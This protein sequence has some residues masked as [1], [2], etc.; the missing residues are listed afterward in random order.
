MKFLPMLLTLAFATPSSVFAEERRLVRAPS[1]LFNCHSDSS[2]RFL[3]LARRGDGDD[4]SAYVYVFEKLGVAQR[5]R[6]IH[7]TALLNRVRSLDSE[8]STDGRFYIT[9]DD[10]GEETNCPLSIVIYDLVRN[11]YYKWSASEF[12]PVDVQKSLSRT[13]DRLHWRDGS[14]AFNRL[15]TRFFPNEPGSNLPFVVV[16]LPTRNVRIESHSH[17][18]E[19]GLEIVTPES[20]DWNPSTWEHSIQTIEQGDCVLPK[21]LKCY[22]RRMETNELVESYY[23]LDES[24]KEYVHTDRSVWE[25]NSQ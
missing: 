20:T 6:L 8:L 21:Y 22:S 15:G 24:L 14:S 5:I 18:G 11:E 16:D 12:L 19:R 23:E 2:G 13:N 1:E 4:A 3:A 9:L 7:Q 25:A 10:L 17:G